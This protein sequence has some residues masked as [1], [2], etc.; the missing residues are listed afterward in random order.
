MNVFLFSL[1]SKQ[2]CPSY[3]RDAA[4][5]D[6]DDVFGCDG[7]GNVQLDPYLHFIYIHTVPNHF[8]HGLIDKKT[9]FMTHLS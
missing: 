3:Q 2:P 4:Q 5:F 6:D 9:A 8:Q 7:D 1:K